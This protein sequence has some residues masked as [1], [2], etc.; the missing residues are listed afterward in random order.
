M[1]V[2]EGMKEASSLSGAEAGIVPA[3]P[4]VSPRWHT[5]LTF[6]LESEALAGRCPGVEQFIGNPVSSSAPGILR[7]AARLLEMPAGQGESV[8]FSRETIGVGLSPPLSCWRV[9]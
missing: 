5:Q 8:F 2:S 4:W 3:H 1:S 6:G 9:F 7:T